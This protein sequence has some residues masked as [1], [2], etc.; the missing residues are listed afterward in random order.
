MIPTVKVRS[1]TLERTLRVTGSTA[2]KRGVMLRAV[3]LARL[4]PNV[5][6]DTP[7][8][9]AAALE[10]LEE[11]ARLAMLDGGLATPLEPAQIAELKQVFGAQW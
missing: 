7:A 11:T 4:G 8:A 9:A 3:M 1:G 5:W 10:E 6:A 2:A